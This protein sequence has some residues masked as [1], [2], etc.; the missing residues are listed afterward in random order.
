MI[1]R[2]LERGDLN[3]WTLSQLKGGCGAKLYCTIMLSKAMWIYLWVWIFKI[4]FKLKTGTVLVFSWW[5][6]QSK[7]T[8]PL[9]HP[10]YCYRVK[11][12]REVNIS[13]D[14]IIHYFI[15]AIFTEICRD[16]LGGQ[17]A[18][19]GG[20]VDLSTWTA[21]PVFNWNLI[22]KKQKQ[23]CAFYYWMVG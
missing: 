13:I 4:K 3:L 23:E 10:F 11:N 9:V 5:G 22:L 19:R 7:L 21:V 8:S 1:W 16:F 6:Q 18:Y 2:Y 14:I 12:H 17:P 20:F 15:W